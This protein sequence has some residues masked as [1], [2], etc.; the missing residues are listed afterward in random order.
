M[1]SDPIFRIKAQILEAEASVLRDES[2]NNTASKNLEK[3]K[4]A[5]E[6]AELRDPRI[7]INKDDV[8]IDGTFIAT[9]SGRRWR[10][11]GKAVWYRYNSPS[12]LLQKIRGVGC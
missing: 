4:L 9:L 6:F 5:L 10:V 7:V 1:L 2:Y 3:L 12:A 8:V 11:Q